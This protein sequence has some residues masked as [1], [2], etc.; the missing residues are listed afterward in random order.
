[1]PQSEPLCIGE[2]GID[3]GADLKPGSVWLAGAGP[4]D[5]GLLTLLALQGLRQADVIVHDALVDSRILDLASARAERYD[6]GKRGG[7]PSPRQAE[8]T[9]RLIQLAQQGLRVLR[10]KGGDPFVFGRGGEEALALS[11]AGIPFRVVPGITAGIAAPAYAGIPATHRDDN[12]A[13][14]FATGKSDSG[15]PN[16]RVLA[17]AGS[18]IVLYMAWRTFPAIA[19]ELKAGGMPGTMPM[20]VI[21]DATTPRQK[22]LI[23][24]LDQGEAAMA[25]SEQKPPAVIV[26][27]SIV[28][29]R[30]NLDWLDRDRL[31]D[32]QLAEQA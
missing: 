4:G 23:T 18:P 7:K 8:I 20:A 13:I 5:P 19:R 25:A 9:T 32:L 30:P 28:R 26:I 14:I 6:M 3:I 22:V 21:S 27:G 29:L 10:L 17:A 2:T 31:A 24:T 15:G 1:M 11:E 16:W 12:Q